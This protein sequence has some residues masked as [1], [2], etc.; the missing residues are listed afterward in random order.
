MISEFKNLRL[1]FRYRS[2][3]LSALKQTKF[4]TQKMFELAVCQQGVFETE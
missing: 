1:F 3:Y 2:G 4:N